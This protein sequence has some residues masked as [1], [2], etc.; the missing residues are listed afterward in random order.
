[1]ETPCNGLSFI[2]SMRFIF[3]N[4]WNHSNE[5]CELIGNGDTLLICG[6]QEAC[7]K[8]LRK[9]ILVVEIERLEIAK[10]FYWIVLKY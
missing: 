8:K 2:Y 4:I 5:V 10:T 1:M 6:N 9:V 3:C 7:D